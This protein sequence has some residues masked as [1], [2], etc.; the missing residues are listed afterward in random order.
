M[1]LPRQGHLEQTAQGDVQVGFK[2]L[3]RGRIHELPGQLFQCSGPSAER[4]SSSCWVELFCGLVCGHCSSSWHWK[5]PGTLLLPPT[6]EVFIYT[7][8]RDPLPVLSSITWLC[9]GLVEKNVLGRPLCKDKCSQENLG[10]KRMGMMSCS[11]AE[12]TL[13]N[14]F[15][16]GSSW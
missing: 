16:H 11:S 2:C 3:R 10:W 8:W 6:S 14:N 13:R 4:N 15:T 12:W 1:P 5:E 9:H 7:H